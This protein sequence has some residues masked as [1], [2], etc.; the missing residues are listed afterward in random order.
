MDWTTWLIPF[1]NNY[2][3]LVAF[4]GGL[5]GGEEIIIPLA[6]LSANDYISPMVV[7]VFCF[8]GLILTDVLIFYTAK[9]K[10]IRGIEYYH[11]TSKFFKKFDEVILKVSRKSIFLALLYSKL[12]FG[13]R[14]I[15]LVYFGI[16]KISIKRFLPSALL[17]ILVWFSL[18]FS[19]GWL[20]GIG[21]SFLID[22]F[23]KVE[24]GI[25]LI[26]LVIIVVIILKK[27]AE[28]FILKREQ[29]R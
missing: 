5:F 29:L 7:F 3:W 8:I 20:A 17:A 6:F 24:L 10:L 23:K 16:K 9:L 25:S 2:G 11:H 1:L 13:T 19:I 28:K 26:F 21:F 18:I 12:V 15:T 4:L 27:W 14:M 22:A